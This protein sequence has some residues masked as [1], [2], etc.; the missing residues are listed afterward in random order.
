MFENQSTIQESREREERKQPHPFKKTMDGDDDDSPTSLSL[1][2]LRRAG[3]QFDDNVTSLSD[4]FASSPSSATL[5]SN[6]FVKKSNENDD[7]LARLCR[8]WFLRFK[9]RDRL[10]ERLPKEFPPESNPSGRFR[11][12]TSYARALNAVLDD[13]TKGT[14]PS[15]KRIGFSH[16]LYPSEQHAREIVSLLCEMIPEGEK[17]ADVF[18]GTGSSASS[19]SKNGSSLSALERAVR[20]ATNAAASSGGASSS[21]SSD[22]RK[23]R[24]M[25]E[26]VN[27]HARILASKQRMRDREGFKL[28]TNKDV[29]WTKENGLWPEGPDDDEGFAVNVLASKGAGGLVAAA[30]NVAGGDKLALISSSR[31]N[32]SLGN[33]D[34][35]ETDAMR[36]LGDK[37]KS[38]A[39]AKKNR[40]DF[41][42]Q[43]LEQRA[44]AREKDL[45]DLQNDVETTRVT[46]EAYVLRCEKAL[47]EMLEYARLEKEERAK[48]PDLEEEYLIRKMAT[49]MVVGPNAAKQS[50]EKAREEMEKLVQEDESRRQDLQK[51]WDDARLPL[52]REIEKRNAKAEAERMRAKEQLEEI[53]RWKEEAKEQIKLARQKAEERDQLLRALERAPKGVNRPSLVQKVTTIVK[54][55]KKQDLEISK[56]VRDAKAAELQVAESAESLRKIYAVVEDA[57]FKAAK[58][59]ETMKMAYRYLHD[60]HKMF[61]KISRDVAEASE[62]ARARGELEKQ[63][64]SLKELNTDSSRVAKDVSVLRKSVKKLEER[65]NVKK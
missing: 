20:V 18:E 10:L 57:I 26:I 60:M 11:A 45:E 4:L 35:E 29:A 33:V 23:R 59:D 62:S 56:I 52:E 37:I 12:A 24:M 58:T 15:S 32:R 13:A 44:E 27:E 54:N 3:V 14:T 25:R 21:S 17:N 1:L 19:S 39:E 34:Q 61:A 30:L 36:R 55:I 47:S 64:D 49:D 6:D 48:F 50:P 9:K 31:N 40:E 65:V 2:S 42:N 43:T 7:A 8:A 5:R 41:A 28:T 46:M 53:Q 51:E 38:A 22:R 16:F 63:M